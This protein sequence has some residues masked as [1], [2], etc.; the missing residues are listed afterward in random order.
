MLGILKGLFYSAIF[1]IG[2]S[3]LGDHLPNIKTKKRRK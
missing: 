3:W 1:F 2:I